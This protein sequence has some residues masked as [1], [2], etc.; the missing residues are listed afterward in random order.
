MGS[1]EI[2]PPFEEVT[3][4]RWDET[5]EY[6]DDND[7]ADDTAQDV[8]DPGSNIVQTQPGKSKS[9]D[10]VRFD[11]LAKQFN[12]RLPQTIN[13]KKFDMSASSNTVFKK[14]FMRSDSHAKQTKTLKNNYPLCLESRGRNLMSSMVLATPSNS[15]KDAAGS[16]AVA[17]LARPEPDRQERVVAC[18]RTSYQKEKMG[19]SAGAA[20]IKVIHTNKIMSTQINHSILPKEYLE[21]IGAEY[22]AGRISGE[23][24]SIA[25]IG[26]NPDLKCVEVEANKAAHVDNH[27]RLAASI[28]TTWEGVMSEHRGWTKVDRENIILTCLIYSDGYRMHVGEATTVLNI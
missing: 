10:S 21:K 9:T 6:D 27:K 17:G 14:K 11:S 15:N 25:T 28:T 7:P 5:V 3:G 2:R 13:Q 12:S 24:A 22:D 20:F 19:P 1:L 4:S 18:F 26:Y 16:T 23:V 8:P